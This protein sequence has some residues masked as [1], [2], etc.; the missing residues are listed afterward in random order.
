MLMTQRFGPPFFEAMEIF[1]VAYFQ[2]LEN[3]LFPADYFCICLFL[4]IGCWLPLISKFIYIW[5][6]T[7]RGT[8]ILTI[9]LALAATDP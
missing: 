7:A 3:H 1:T 6:N 9:S 8:I 4:D 5:C 2:L